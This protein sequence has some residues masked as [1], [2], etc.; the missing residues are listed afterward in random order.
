MLF[1]C[2]RRLDWRSCASHGVST[3][4][5]TI[6]VMEADGTSQRF[7]PRRRRFGAPCPTEHPIREAARGDRGESDSTIPLFAKEA[8]AP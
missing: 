2:F 6:F 3:R 4:F 8:I 1:I 7:A 5:G